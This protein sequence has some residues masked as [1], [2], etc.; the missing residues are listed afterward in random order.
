MNIA[1]VEFP[2]LSANPEKKKKNW[3]T[4]MAIF[5]ESRRKALFI[6]YQHFSTNQRQQNYYPG[7]SL[8]C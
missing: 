3:Q 5:N 7:L 1:I 4:P 8:V 2:G 6:S